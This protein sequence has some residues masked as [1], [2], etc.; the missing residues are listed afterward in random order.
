VTPQQVAVLL[1]GPS[2]E[3]DVS[4][5]SGRAIAGALAE[6]GH[7]VQGWLIGLDG[8]WWRLPQPALAR[9]LPATAFDDPR[10]L[11]AEGPMGASAALERLAGHVPM[12]VVFPA[13]HGPFGEDGTVQALLA[14]ADLTACGSGVG[15]SAIGMSKHLFKRLCGAM[16][17][18]VLPWV[19]VRADAW[20]RDQR[21]V[22]SELE[23]FA[24]ELPD[25]RLV[26]KPASLGS[27][28]GITI[29]HR[30]DEPPA[31]EQA[32]A[33]ALR[34]DDLA[35]AEPYLDHPRELE[36]AVLGNSRE[37]LEVFGPGE[38]VP[39]REFYD[40][41]AKYRDSGSRT[42]TTPALD[43]ALRADIRRISAEVFLAIGA[44]GFA[45]VDF[46]LGQDDF[47]VVS[48]INT[49]PGFTPI[50]LFPMLC[51]EGGYDFGD[52]CERIVALALEDAAL[53]PS[54]RLTRE[55]LP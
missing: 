16:E 32:V 22:V 21:S 36:A 37:D 42:T 30:P 33:D 50:S 27:S 44:A 7:A 26:V 20:A 8:A 25:P 4:L 38:I 52:V 17:L 34:Y 5:V 3:H 31:L 53:R 39:G 13:L 1:G 10:A 54:R 45:R 48:E 11:G 28:I 15:A 23:A 6:R 12:P 43:E 14:S 47:L 29:V 46:L 51:A 41:I 35:L 18:P 40:Y 19:E 2:A 55:D 24:Q 49:V 9:Q